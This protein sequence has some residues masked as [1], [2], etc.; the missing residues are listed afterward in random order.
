[1][2]P[3]RLASRPKRETDTPEQLGNL[4]ALEVLRLDNVKAVLR[5]DVRRSHP[6]GDLVRVRAGSREQ[7]VK[8]TRDQ[9]LRPGV[10]Q[11]AIVVV[12]VGKHD[13]LVFAGVLAQGVHQCS[14]AQF[15]DL[16]QPG[17]TLVELGGM[18]PGVSESRR[19]CVELY[20]A[21]HRWPSP[22]GF[23]FVSHSASSSA[24]FS[25]TFLAINLGHRCPA[26]GDSGA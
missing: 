13:P 9:R 20:D 7:Q 3:P 5:P 11:H 19:G 1:M 12:R 23:T 18:A 4:R 24:R 2:M 26:N 16:R 8:R 6:P 17:Q 25:I 22:H 21:P 15:L 10:Y 14:R